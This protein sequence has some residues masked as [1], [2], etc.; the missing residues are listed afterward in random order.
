MDKKLRAFYEA[1]N[2]RLDDWQEVDAIVKAV[3]DDVLETLD[4]VDVDGDGSADPAGG[5]YNHD[6]DVTTLLPE[7]QQERRR[8]DEKHAQWAINVGTPR[9]AFATVADVSSGQRHCQHLSFG[10]QARGLLLFRFPLP[11]RLD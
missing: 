8:R 7:D 9:S 11:H 2:D 6:E 4:P 5:L 1:H 3:S 10:C